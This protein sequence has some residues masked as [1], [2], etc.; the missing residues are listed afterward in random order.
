MTTSPSNNFRLGVW[1]P[2]FAGTTAVFVV[3]IEISPA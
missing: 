3:E 1:I 2:A